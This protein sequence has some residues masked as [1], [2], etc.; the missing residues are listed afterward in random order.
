M[1]DPRRHDAAPIPDAVWR[2]LIR[3][4][5]LPCALLTGA[6]PGTLSAQD[7]FADSAAVRRLKDSV[8]QHSPELIARRAALEAAR[9][10]LG[11]TGFAP[12]AALGVELEE[13]PGGLDVGDAGSVRLDLSREL[14]S[15]ALRSAQRALAERD[16]ERAQAELELAERSVGARVDRALTL[17]VGAAAI[18]RRLAAEDSLLA[19]AEEGVRTRFAVGEA[20][21]VDVLRLRTERLRIR[22]DAAAALS[23]ARIGRTL[24]VSLLTP[25]MATE[26]S[27]SMIDS[28]VAGE[29]RDPLRAPLP[30][31]PSLDSL[32]AVSAPARFGNI[33]VA[34]A[35]SARRLARAEQ[36][37]VIA[38]SIGVQRFG[39]D[40]GGY[41]TGPTLGASV[42][43]PFTA[44]RANQAALT[45]A[46]REIAAAEAARQ[47]AIANVRANLTAARER[48]EAARERLGLFDAALLRGAREERES[49]LAAYRTGDLSLIELLDFERALARAE[50]ERLRSRIDAADAFADLIA[51]VA[52]DSDDSHSEFILPPEGD[53]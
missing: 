24:L 34:R 11:A 41:T 52:G 47:A 3:V 10:R 35:R 51:G 1:F 48:Y 28:I 22:T 9:A 32:I 26:A 5:A 39:D 31:A 37:P 21:Y 38:A 53:R 19:S 4:V 13:V 20:R 33:A 8:R 14:F 27:A 46:D 50:I 44:R 16:V 43:L 23:E 15:G 6:L 40:E 49:A 36:R 7:L 45:A 18:A 42:S 2:R 29:L 25:D 12:A 17:S 30:A